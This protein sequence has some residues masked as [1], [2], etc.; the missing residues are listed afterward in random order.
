[1]LKIVII[2]D[3]VLRTNASEVPIAD[4]KEP[5]IQQVIADMKEVVHS[6]KFGVA[7]AAPQINVPLRMFVI[8]GSVLAIK[9]D[10]DYDPKVHTDQVFINPKI[11]KSSKKMKVGDEGCL[12]IPGS[13]GTQVLRHEKVTISYYD[14]KGNEHERGASGFLARVF[15]HEV[16]HLNGILYVDIA[17]EP[18]K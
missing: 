13:Y 5:A 17:T 2:G 11:L 3:S 1:M 12:S 15:Q 4:I 10:E 16:D 14:E 9:K 6:E 18:L 8:S 7:I